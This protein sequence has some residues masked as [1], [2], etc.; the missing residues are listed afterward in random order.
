[1]LEGEVV[2]RCVNLLCP[3]MM[4]EALKH[5]ASRNAMN[6]EKLGD[7]LIETLFE[8]ELVKSSLIFIR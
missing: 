5:F 8:A 1:M 2:K 4:K 6:I 7:R 3:A